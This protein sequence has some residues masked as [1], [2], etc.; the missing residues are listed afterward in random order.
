MGGMDNAT[1]IGGSCP[2]WRPHL[3]RRRFGV[4]ACMRVDI[5][6]VS[7]TNGERRKSCPIQADRSTK[8]DLGT[9][10]AAGDVGMAVS[11]FS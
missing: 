7:R 3:H 9:R 4:M 6:A 1:T 5:A 8:Q 11:S 2:H 10:S